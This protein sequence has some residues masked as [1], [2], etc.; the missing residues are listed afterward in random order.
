MKDLTAELRR[1]EATRM[2]RAHE[3][4]T[5]TQIISIPKIFLLLEMWDSEMLNVEICAYLDI[6]SADLRKLAR[7]FELGHRR[8]F[9]RTSIELC[10][11]VEKAKR[12]AEIRRTWS[13]EERVR[14]LGA[15]MASRWTPPKAH[16]SFQY[17]PRTNMLAAIK[18]QAAGARE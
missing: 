18:D 15:N 10:G 9:C 12:A 1:A 7:L 17:H 13:E 11:P 3:L 8:T 4:A 2:R 14:R 5:K 16:T 6:S